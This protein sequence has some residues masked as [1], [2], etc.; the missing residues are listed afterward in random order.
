MEKKRERLFSEFAPVSRQEWLDKITVDLKGADFGKKLVWR[1][2]EGFNVQ[3]FY[4]KE[5]VE[6][7]PTVTA[8]PGQF[9]FVRGN[10]VSDN[11]WYVRQN[12][13]CGDA[14]ETNKKL[15][16]LLGRGIDSLGLSIPRDNVNA[17][18]LEALLEGII[19]EAIEL[20]FS[21]C[22]SVTLQ[23]AKEVVAY[24]DKHVQDKSQ[25][26]GSIDF[27]PI[28]KM[29]KKGKDLTAR[30]A[31]AKEMV[32]IVK[33]Y[34]G[35]TCITVSSLE[36][37]NAGAFCYQESGYAL[38][39]GNEYLNLL[40]EAGV[41]AREAVRRMRFSMAAGGNYFMEIAK[42]RAFRMSWANIVREYG[43]PEE[44]CRAY[45]M[46]TTAEY[47]KT[48]F[49][50]YVN[51]LRTQ[52]EA[53]SAALAGVESLVVTE[54][55]TPYE[56]PTDFSER[57]ARNQQLML[58]EEN[59]FSKIVDVAAGS[60]YIEELTVSIAAEA[61]KL[62]LAVEQEGGFL[63]AVKTGTVQEKVNA[64]NDERHK[65]AAQRREFILGTNQ[66]PNFTEVSEGKQPLTCQCC[67]HSDEAPAF[68]KLNQ[69]RLSSDFE[70]LRL[71]TERAEKRPVAFM[72]TIGDLK[73]RQ[74]RAQFSCNFLASAGYQVID[75]LGFP[76]VEEGIEAAMEAGAD[77]V[78]IC[79][80]DEEYAQYAIPA[81]NALDGRALFIVAGAPACA[82][83][84]KAAGI[85][86]FIHVR[87][88]QLDTLKELN[89][90]LGIK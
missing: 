74:A 38:A 63:A 7:L 22:P 77:I 6:K 59:H 46:A 79:S 17:E 34:P 33:D 44:E 75:N 8:L 89:A 84:L 35:M 57:I 11:N 69:T 16:D 1:T 10:K 23:L 70:A 49:D 78:V 9:P 85:E 52:T 4:L 51:L 40:T 31:D 19:P 73:W 90:K 21:T 14:K 86:Y 45:I 72:L 60:Y 18:Y 62:F 37:Q 67:C 68:P 50:S 83:D 48:L 36:L 32:D 25:I 43:V 54:F 58:K 13:K 66:F 61:W 5:D 80:S 55:N 42:F 27:D 30:L 81:Y 15:L 56:Q 53:M 26:H 28:G 3:P 20:N 39:W 12:V 47:N 64:T 76:T 29:L 88:N 71:A 24:L 82:E 2:D 87:V 65:K 41:E